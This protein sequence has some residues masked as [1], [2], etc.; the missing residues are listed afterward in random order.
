MM[1]SYSGTTTRNIAKNAIKSQ[2]IVRISTTDYDL[3]AFKKHKK[4]ILAAAKPVPTALGGG[5]HVHAYLVNDTAELQELTGNDNMIQAP[6]PHPGSVPNIQGADSHATIALKTSQKAVELD[7][8]YTQLGCEAGLQ[9]L[10]IKNAPR[11]ALAELKDEDHG[12]ANVTA[13]QLLQYLQSNAEIV[14]DLTLTELL[15]LRDQPMDFEADETLKTFFINLKK[16]IK[17]LTGHR[18]ITSTSELMTK[19]IIQIQRQG[20]TIFDAHLEVWRHKEDADKTWANFITFWETADRK[21]RVRNKTTGQSKLADRETANNIESKAAMANM[22]EAAMNN[23]AEKADEGIN[24]VIESKFK[25]LGE[26]NNK[27]LSELQK[28]NENLKKKIAEM[29]KKKAG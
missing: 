15:R 22:F 13:L 19:Y 26:G 21:R 27:K 18:I 25:S 24:A 16:R 1:A 11:L 4:S 29:E 14:D 20:D 5:Q 23:F 17:D 3:E 28:Q 8:Y 10:I 2:R 9:E 6:I 7:T 12:F